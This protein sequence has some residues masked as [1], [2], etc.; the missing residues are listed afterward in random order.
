MTKKSLSPLDDLNFAM[1]TLDEAAEQATA[2]R[3]AVRS[4]GKRGN[5]A[6]KRET[7][8][9]NLLLPVDQLAWLD[10]ITAEARS[11]KAFRQNAI[12]VA[13]FDALMRADL[14]LKGVKSEEEIQERVISA[15]KSKL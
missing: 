4:K 6:P 14:T 11:A 15:I 8:Q 5:A 1:P 13:I 9:R 7:R 12:V 3:D 2:E 10:E